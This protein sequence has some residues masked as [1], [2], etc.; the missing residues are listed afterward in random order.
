MFELRQFVFPAVDTCPGFLTLLVSWVLTLISFLVPSSG[1]YQFYEPFIFIF[2]ALINAE[3]AWGEW[4]ALRQTY[5]EVRI[6]KLTSGCSGI[7]FTL[8]YYWALCAKL[9]PVQFYFVDLL[10]S[11]TVCENWKGLSFCGTL[12]WMCPSICMAFWRNLALHLYQ[13]KQLKLYF[14]KSASD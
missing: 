13:G 1:L 9:I 12:C 11:F 4:E 3:I 2:S 7:F 6:R 10:D 14:L 5:R 8:F